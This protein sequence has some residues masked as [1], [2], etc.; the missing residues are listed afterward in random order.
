MEITRHLAENKKA[1]VM[2]TGIKLGSKFNIKDATK[3][4]YQHDFIYS[5][6]CL[7]ETCDKS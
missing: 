2:Y 5:A 3:K 1:Q 7:L 4:E 6:K